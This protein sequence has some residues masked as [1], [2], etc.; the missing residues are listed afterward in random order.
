MEM[1]LGLLALRVILALLIGAHASQ[2]LF[3]WFRGRGI[4]GTAALF[5]ADGLRPGTVMVLAAGLTELGAATLLAIGF[6]TPL[7]A[8]MTIGTMVVA[9]STLWPKGVWAHMGGFEVPLTYAAIAFCL[10]ITGPGS[11]ALDQFQPLSAHGPWWA[12]GAAGLALVAS[13][14]LVA[15]VARHRGRTSTAHTA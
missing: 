13:S 15:V 5:E 7:A 9:I 14:P 6:A 11:Y 3:G 4:A 2:K 8:A 1:D 10:A 12:L